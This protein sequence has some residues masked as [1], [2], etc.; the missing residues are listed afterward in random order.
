MERH[1]LTKLRSIVL[2]GQVAESDVIPFDLQRIGAESAHLVDVG[3][4]VVGDDSA[5]RTLADEVHILQPRGDNHFLLIHAV[6]DKYRHFIIHKGADT[7]HRFSQGAIVTRAVARYYQRIFP[8]SGSL[9][10]YGSSC[11]YQYRPHDIQIVFHL[12][13]SLFI[14]G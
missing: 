6:L 9:N 1:G 11:K 3:V 7:L 12:V 14:L 13:S 5:F 4:V 10:L 8:L 2:D